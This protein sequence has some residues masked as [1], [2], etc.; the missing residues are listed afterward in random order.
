MSSDDNS[1]RTGPQGTQVFEANQVNKMIA[2]EIV[3][4]QPED[5]NQAALVGVSSDMIGQTY[6]LKKSKIE[7][8][9]RPSSDIVLSDPSVSAM[10]AQIIQDNDNWKVLNLL[11]SNGT[12]VNGEK[13]VEKVL[14]KG[15]MVGFA[16]SEFVF[17]YIKGEEAPQKDKISNKILFPIIIG[18][19]I[20]AAGAYIYFLNHR[21]SKSF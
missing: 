4:S 10:H 5:A 6:A 20:L 12:F 9:R 15:D 2:K 17:S 16:G 13:V 7:V 21:L 18:A 8:G 1:S 14:T 3:D 19:A 11:S